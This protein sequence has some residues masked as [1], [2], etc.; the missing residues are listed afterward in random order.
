[1][2]FSVQKLEFHSRFWTQLHNRVDMLTEPGYLFDIR[3]TPSVKSDVLY[4]K[5]TYA[6]LGVGNY[7]SFLVI[8]RCITFGAEYRL[9]K[10]HIYLFIYLFIY[11]DRACFLVLPSMLLSFIEGL[12]QLFKAQKMII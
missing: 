2:K 10:L 4:P 6:F 7:V 5:S 1:M 3:N 8:E 11:H 9:Q 12:K